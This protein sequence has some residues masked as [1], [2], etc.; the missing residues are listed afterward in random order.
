MSTEHLFRLSVHAYYAGEIDVGLRACERLLQR[1]LLGDMERLVR[2]N[3]TWYTPP[4]DALVPVTCVPITIAPAHEGWTLFNPSIL[5][6]FNGYLVNVRSSNYRIVDG[7]YVMPAADNGTIRTE[8][9]LLQLGY[10]S[11][12]DSPTN[13]TVVSADYP[14]TDYPVHGLEDVRLNCIDGETIASATIRNMHPHDGTCR[15]AVARVLPYTRFMFPPVCHATPDGKHEKNWMPILGRRQ[16]LYGCH[17]H[18]RVATATDTGDTW[19]ITFH[20]ESPPIA[21]GFRGGSQL[22]PTGDRR[23]WLALVHEVAEDAGRRIY[24][25][26]FVVFDEEADWQIVKVSPPFSFRERRAIEFAA[27]LARTGDELV[28]SFGVRDEEAWL[29]VTS[30]TKVLEMLHAP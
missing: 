17:V 29:A 9:I 10:A 18:G 4:L 25:H 19:A 1:E 23:Q 15:I 14:A 30:L 3:R 7:K 13:P 27:G 11:G 28:A 12:L 22:I 26:R 6:D 8:N 20:A 21:R 16:W 2:S 24:E 5:A